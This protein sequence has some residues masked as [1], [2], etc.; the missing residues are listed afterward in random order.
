MSILI[1]PK[2]VDLDAE[3]VPAYIKKTYENADY[4]PT[5]S[6]N[7]P[8]TTDLLF[9]GVTDIG[10]LRMS[11]F[12]VAVFTG[13]AA[14]MRLAEFVREYLNFDNTKGVVLLT[15]I[16]IITD[17]HDN[18]NLFYMDTNPDD[19]YN[20]ELKSRLTGHWQNGFKK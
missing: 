15:G 9:P 16:N 5:T 2:P 14:P 6:D 19:E 7:P 17:S 4:V 18:F 1:G 8:E 12:R 3:N 20:K 10:A 11:M 13:Y